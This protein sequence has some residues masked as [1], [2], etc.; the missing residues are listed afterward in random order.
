MSARQAGSGGLADSIRLAKNP[1]TRI[2][3]AKTDLPRRLFVSLE[4]VIGSFHAPQ[5]VCV[6]ILR[7]PSLARLDRNSLREC[8]K[9]G[10]E[11]PSDP[12]RGSWS[13]NGCFHRILGILRTKQDH[14]CSVIFH[15]IRFDSVL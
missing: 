8:E 15:D 12:P 9:P 10:I 6:R 1:P 4:K 5:N 11:I 2:S 7:N 14:H 13:A 3:I